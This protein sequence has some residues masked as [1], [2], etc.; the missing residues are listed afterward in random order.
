MASVTSKMASASPIPQGTRRKPQLFRGEE[1]D[2]HEV[3]EGEGEGVRE[4]N[5]FDEVEVDS[6]GDPEM[7]RIR[8]FPR[9]KGLLFTA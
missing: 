2:A 8:A 4:L 9:Q 6:T 7:E 1:A 5:E 3:S